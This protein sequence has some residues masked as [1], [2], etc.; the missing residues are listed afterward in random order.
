MTCTPS[1]AEEIK[2]GEPWVLNWIPLIL[3]NRQDP[4]CFPQ[5]HPDIISGYKVGTVEETQH[6]VLWSALRTHTVLKRG[7]F[8][9]GN[10]EAA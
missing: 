2:G 4:S 3:T 9:L 8:V 1:T 5:K 6:R 7:I 10:Q